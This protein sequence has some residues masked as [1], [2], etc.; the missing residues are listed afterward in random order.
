M[1][2]YA[3]IGNERVR[4]VSFVRT[5]PA[6]V[7]RGLAVLAGAYI[8][9]LFP[10][11]LYSLPGIGLDPSWSEVIAYAAREHWQWGRQIVFTYGPLGY[12]SPNLYSESLAATA[13]VLNG[14]LAVALAAGIIA[15]LPRQP[16]V[17]TI[18]L[19]ILIT[20]PAA[21]M[22]RLAFTVLPLLAALLH[23]RPREPRPRFV[24]VILAAASGLF[25]VIYASSGVLAVG[26]LA[27]IDWDRWMRRRRPIFLAVFLVA[28]LAAYLAAD[29]RLGDLPL[30]LRSTYELIA[31]YASGMS[32][33]GSRVELAVFIV[34]SVGAL[35]LVASGERAYR[36]DVERRGDTWLLLAALAVFWLVTFKTGFVRHDL[37][38]RAAWL[39]LAFA[40]AGYVGLRWEA[41]GGSRLRAPIIALSILATVASIFVQ[42]GDTQLT[43]IADD[44]FRVLVRRPAAALDEAMAAMRDPAAWAAQRREQQRAA[45]A[46]IRSAVPL[47]PVAGSVD[48]IPNVQS[49]VIAHG[50]RYRPR[51]VFQDYA[52]YTPWLI[53][54]NREHY[55]GPAAPEH[56]LFR[57]ETID[58]RYPLLDQ[59][60][61]VIELLSRYDPER[62]D[63]TLLDLRR[64]AAP[65]TFALRDSPEFEGALG[66]WIDVDGTD[67]L[68]ILR[69]EVT[70]NLLGRLASF[71][72]RPPILHI[73]VRLADG[74]ERE[75]RLVSGTARAGF[76]LSPLVDSALA[77][78]ALALDPRA[79]ETGRRIVAFKIDA[80][81]PTGS[82]L[83]NQTMQLQVASLQ[84]E[85]EGAR[86][87]GVDLRRALKRQSIASR[88]AERSERKAPF[89]EAIETELYAHAPATLSLPVTTASRLRASYA[90]RP[91]AFTGDGSTDGVCFRV[92]A[93]TEGGTVRK[94]FERCL[95]PRARAED[96]PPQTLDVAV[97]LTAPGALVFETDCRAN[98]TWDWSYWKNIDV[99]P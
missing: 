97:G 57:P 16:I 29:Q 32:I 11:F 72:L 78:A 59:A 38:T 12:L 30:F 22:G 75:F 81:T 53:E 62:I 82:H 33:A 49:S 88:L 26:V 6:G 24:P 95:D 41:L 67:A 45:H 10:P 8:V 9:L 83:Y 7:R 27:L 61:T 64:R 21:L 39:A 47:P 31:G 93:A 55:R 40:L 60:T 15:L 14:M 86:S 99:E 63:G 3:R 77:F 85:G 73:A 92:S 37:H 66:Q 89:V 84:M 51:P 25:A 23:F 18:G 5:M 4:S 43:S 87:S 46:A 36:R 20:L 13:M 35:V 2:Q 48:V 90:I 56:V 19:F 98:C 91:G 34:S 44:A 79:V 70:P 50:L 74:R 68:V 58:N 71:A 52:A 54:Q 80:V 69:A 96:R 94:L 65:L 28:A 76:L 17:V 42:H 1:H